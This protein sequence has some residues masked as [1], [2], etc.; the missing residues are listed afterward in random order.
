MFIAVTHQIGN[1]SQQENFLFVDQTCLQDALPSK[2]MKI[3]K[4]NLEEDWKSERN[5]KKCTRCK[6]KE[7]KRA[8]IGKE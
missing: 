3:S 1:Q 4:P 5:R 8:K 2:N 7:E 6:R